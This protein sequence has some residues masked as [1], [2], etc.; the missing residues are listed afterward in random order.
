M[1]RVADLRTRGSAQGSEDYADVNDRLR[2]V[3]S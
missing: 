3:S 2:S 1:N